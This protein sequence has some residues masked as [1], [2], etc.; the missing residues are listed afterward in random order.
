MLT[1]FFSFVKTSGSPQN[2]IQI[3]ILMGIAYV[4]WGLLHH[5][6][7]QDLNWKV[8]IEYIAIAALGVIFLSI[9]IG[10]IA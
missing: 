2:Q 9:L 8:V 4:V 6:N 10:L 1:G 3:G 7:D 5:W